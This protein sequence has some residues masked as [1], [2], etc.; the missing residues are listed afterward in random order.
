M[1]PKVEMKVGKFYLILGGSIIQSRGLDQ[2]F[3]S[4]ALQEVTA[5]DARLL[6]V[7]HR[8]L[9]C[10]KLY[11]EAAWIEE[12]MSELGVKPSEIPKQFQV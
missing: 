1:E 3:G 6:R 2:G 9:R 7:R 5:A 8:G 4:K 10:R 11:E 12:I